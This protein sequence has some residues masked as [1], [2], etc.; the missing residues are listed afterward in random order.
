MSFAHSPQI[1]T[2][3]L[4]LALDAGN[5]KS[6]VSGS[7]TWFDKSGYGNNGTLTNGPTFSSANGGSIV[8][9]GVDDYV[10]FD[11]SQPSSLFSTANGGTTIQ[12]W[13]YTALST[14]PSPTNSSSIFQDRYITH[15]NNSTLDTLFRDLQKKRLINPISAN[16]WYNVA[17][18]TT[19]FKMYINGQEQILA[20]IPYAWGTDLVSPRIGTNYYTSFIGKISN[21]QVY[22]RALTQAEITQNFNALRGRFGI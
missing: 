19:N 13:L 7:T 10:S 9:D 18:D 15:V 21:F 4:V 3:G 22:N 16:V 1:I 17:I 5:I 11:I 12:Y 20:N 2:N 8:F 6:Y 14:F